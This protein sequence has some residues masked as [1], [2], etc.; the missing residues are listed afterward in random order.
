MTQP[1]KQFEQMGLFPKDS[2]PQGGPAFQSPEEFRDD[3]RTV[4]HASYRRIP[5]AGQSL[6]S[7]FP[8]IHAGT[9]QAALERAGAHGHFDPYTTPHQERADNSRR[10]EVNPHIVMQPLSTRG[11]PIPEDHSLGSVGNPMTD[12]EANNQNIVNHAQTA[13]TYINSAEDIGHLSVVF[14]KRPDLMQQ[15]DWVRKQRNE[16]YQS[17]APK[18]QG[19]HPR[20][21]AMY[22]AKILDNYDMRTRD[23]VKSETDP[24]QLDH[25]QHDGGL[26]PYSESNK[27]APKDPNDLW[28]KW[29]QRLVSREEL[30][31]ISKQF[32]STHP[33]TRDPYQ[34]RAPAH[35]HEDSW[36]SSSR[37]NS[38]VDE[39]ETIR[40]N[41]GERGSKMYSNNYAG[42]S[43]AQNYPG[44]GDIERSA[45]T[46]REDF[47]NA[48]HEAAVAHQAS[49]EAKGKE[50]YEKVHAKNVAKQASLLPPQTEYPRSSITGK[51]YDPSKPISL[52]NPLPLKKSVPGVNVPPITDKPKPHNVGNQFDGKWAP[53]NEDL[54]VGGGVKTPAKK[55]PSKKAAIPAKVASAPK[56]GDSSFD[57]HEYAYKTKMAAPYNPADYQPGG[58]YA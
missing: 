18:D 43:H 38:A 26:F 33:I 36:A 47:K 55:A 56:S 30:S 48:K 14:P 53:V 19:I 50:L 31:G 23:Q 40:A 4:F 21:A 24:Q 15:G 12:D 25:H 27:K 54:V 10:G 39:L 41:A 58:K 9:Y 1:G 32:G 44:L 51:R 29:D 6:P 3:P 37:R 34:D 35:S 52:E 17:G 46:A 49:I 28:P 2:V 57:I 8:G 45:P 7:S 20:T 11:L 16:N 5:E 42:L 22:D 13:R